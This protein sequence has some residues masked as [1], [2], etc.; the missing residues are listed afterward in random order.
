LSRAKFGEYVGGHV[1][2]SR[3]VLKLNPLE[4]SFDFADLST[5]GIHGIFDVAPL[6]VDLFNDDL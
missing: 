3:Y 4:V 2:V 6:F 5:V 1:V